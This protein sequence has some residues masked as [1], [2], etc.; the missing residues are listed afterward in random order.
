VDLFRALLL[1][2]AVLCLVASLAAPKAQLPL[3]VAAGGFAVA[4]L[5]FRLTTT[6]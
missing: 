1:T 4:D 6:E 5:L 2:L 3:L